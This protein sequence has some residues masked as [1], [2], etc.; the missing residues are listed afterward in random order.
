MGIPCVI[1]V[2]NAMTQLRDGDRIRVDGG[3]GVVTVLARAR[4][5]D[6]ADPAPSAAG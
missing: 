1:N 6:E 4:A 5:H 2:G 3:A